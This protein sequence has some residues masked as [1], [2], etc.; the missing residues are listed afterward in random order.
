MTESQSPQPGQPWARSQD[1][2]TIGSSGWVKFGLTTWLAGRVLSRAEI[3]MPE[4]LEGEPGA[5]WLDIYVEEYVGITG[6]SKHGHIR[7]EEEA[8]RKLYQI[9]H[10]KFG[11]QS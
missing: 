2:N 6:R 7:L 4:K 11:G 3:A 1:I 8:M 9:L 10:A 5:T